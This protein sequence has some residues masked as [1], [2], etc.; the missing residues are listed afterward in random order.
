MISYSG[1][2]IQQ[3]G[4]M[5]NAKIEKF[6][7]HPSGQKIDRELEELLSVF[8]YK[9]T[10]HSISRDE[11]LVSDFHLSLYPSYSHI[12][13]RY[14]KSHAPNFIAFFCTYIRYTFLNFE[15]KNK[16]PLE[17]SYEINLNLDSL[18]VA[19]EPF[20]YKPEKDKQTELY[21]LLNHIPFFKRLVFKLRM[22]IP[23]DR[24]EIRF[25]LERGTDPTA[26]QEFFRKSEDQESQIWNKKS[27]S[28]DRISHL[29]VLMHN[30]DSADQARYN[31]LKRRLRSNQKGFS[32]NRNLPYFDQIA[33]L[34]Q[35][36][37]SNARKHF[38]SASRIA[39]HHYQSI[40]HSS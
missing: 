29:L 25:I 26:L 14:D 19:E 23:L 18:K 12:I 4:D 11:D 17:A 40:K 22:R 3:I 37:R 31:R 30:N 28:A 20:I 7:E 13:D 34:L 2:S 35:I 8:I 27:S 5:I 39:L 24:R 16:R 38:L 32:E 33:A 10:Y 6:R 15:R 1:L 21:F 9:Y 36:S